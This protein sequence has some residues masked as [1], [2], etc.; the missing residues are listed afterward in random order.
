MKDIKKIIVC[1]GML[2]PEEEGSKGTEWFILNVFS[3]VKIDEAFN[4]NNLVETV[5]LDLGVDHPLEM[6]GLASDF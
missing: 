4:N 1:G 6:Q 2:V 5:I 3:I